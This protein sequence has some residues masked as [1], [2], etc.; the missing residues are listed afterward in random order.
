MQKNC[1]AISDPMGKP[2]TVQ[3]SQDVPIVHP[4]IKYS[5]DHFVH[6]TAFTDGK[7]R[8][9]HS[10][11]LIKRTVYKDAPKVQFD[12]VVG[13]GFNFNWILIS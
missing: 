2:C 10:K 3:M 12:D 6:N 7:Y 5:R 1:G 11:K 4:V 13:F 8:V 9:L